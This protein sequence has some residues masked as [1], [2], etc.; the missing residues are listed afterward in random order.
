MHLP[1]CVCSSGCTGERTSRVTLRESRRVKSLKIYSAVQKLHWWT[2]DFDSHYRSSL[3][4]GICKGQSLWKIWQGFHEGG[5]CQCFMKLF[6]NLQ[7]FSAALKCFSKCLIFLCPRLHFRSLC[8]TN[9]VPMFSCPITPE[10]KKQPF[11][12]KADWQNKRAYRMLHKRQPNDERPVHLHNVWEKLK[13]NFNNQVSSS[14]KEFLCVHLNSCYVFLNMSSHLAG[15]LELVWGLIASTDHGGPEGVPP[16]SRL[17][18]GLEVNN[19]KG[20]LI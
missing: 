14:T 17:T 6:W 9:N 7:A 5:K 3:Y 8:Q 16:V 4:P 11:A 19:R 1:G 20:C 18:A 12:F 13:E 2:L 10:K 15:W